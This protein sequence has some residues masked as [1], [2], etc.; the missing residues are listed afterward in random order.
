[1]ERRERGSGTTQW[2]PKP[3]G[4][5]GAS[6]AGSSFPGQPHTP[7]NCVHVGPLRGGGVGVNRSPAGLS[8]PDREILE[9]QGLGVA[10]RPGMTTPLMG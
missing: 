4:L 6:T 2:F 1:M 3:P 5:Q 7:G 9:I 8:F 10:V